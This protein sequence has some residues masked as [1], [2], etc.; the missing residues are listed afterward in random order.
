M[1][2]EAV[3]GRALLD[4]GISY[5]LPVGPAGHARHQGCEQMY[6][7][8][9]YGMNQYLLRQKYMIIPLRFKLGGRPVLSAHLNGAGTRVA[10]G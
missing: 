9:E 6:G 2:A 8:V 3:D 4:Y 5:P 1:L 7:G 10:G